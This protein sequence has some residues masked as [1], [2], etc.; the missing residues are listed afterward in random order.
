MST[1]IHLRPL[2]RVLT[3]CSGKVGGDAA[4]RAIYEKYQTGVITI[5][6]ISGLIKSAQKYVLAL[7]P[8]WLLLDRLER[9]LTSPLLPSSPPSP[10]SFS[11]SCTATLLTTLARAPLCI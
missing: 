6:S 4:G 7:N 11:S 9:R 1:D 10:L 2:R 8:L 3:T 5:S